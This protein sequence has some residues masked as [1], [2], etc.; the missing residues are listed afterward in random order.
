MG[1]TGCPQAL[2]IEDIYKPDELKRK[3]V[4]VTG[5][6][7][8]LGLALCKEL[9]Q[10]GAEVV[11][12]V[13]KASPELLQLGVYQTIEGIDVTDDAAVKTMATKVKGQ[14]DVVIN[15]AGIFMKERESLLSDTMDFADEVRTIDVCAVGPL[16]VVA[17]LWNGDKIKTG[18]K[19][20]MITSQGGSV[21][22]RAV[23]SP[24]GGDYGHHM[25]KSA[26]NMAAVLCANELRGKISVGVLH[27]GFNRT[28]MT[29]KYSH[30]WDIEGAVESSVGAKRV[31]HEINKLG[32]ATSGKFINCEDGLE[33]P[34]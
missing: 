5:A 3:R 8:G 18:G 20:V 19:I 11:A 22:W 17:A 4:L 34:F 7:R 12:V 28:E 2:R 6:N 24:S 30:I 32:P 14:V 23:Q 16:R 25:S 13:R 21:H 9:V 29:A 26:A 1:E 33:I 15:N 27:P 31:C 10:C